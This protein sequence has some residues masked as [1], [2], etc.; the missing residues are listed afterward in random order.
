[1]LDKKKYMLRNWWSTDIVSMLL[2][3]HLKYLA[4]FAVGEQSLDWKVNWQT[5]RQKFKKDKKNCEST[6]TAGAR[7]SSNHSRTLSLLFLS[8][9]WMDRRRRQEEGSPPTAM[10]CFLDGQEEVG[11]LIKI[12]E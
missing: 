4:Q 9:V 6:N 12:M 1:V 8:L 5:Q 2:A 11:T 3:H 7:S 10:L